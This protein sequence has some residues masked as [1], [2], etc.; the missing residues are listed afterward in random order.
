MF[1]LKLVSIFETL[2][3]SAGRKGLSRERRMFEKTAL[4]AVAMLLFFFGLSIAFIVFS[5]YLWSRQQKAS[6]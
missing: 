4:D 2:L 5:G 6:N 3:F 1:S